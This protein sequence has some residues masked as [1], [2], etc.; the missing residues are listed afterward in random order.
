MHAKNQETYWVTNKHTEEFLPGWEMMKHRQWMSLCS[1]CGWYFSISHQDTYE[2]P[3]TVVRPDGIK[4]TLF[5]YFPVVVMVDIIRHLRAVSFL[6]DCLT[7]KVVNSWQ[8]DSFQLKGKHNGPQTCR[9]PCSTARVQPGRAGLSMSVWA[10]TKVCV[11]VWCVFTAKI[12]WLHEVPF[13]FEVWCNVFEPTRVC[14]CVPCPSSVSSG[15]TGCRN[16]WPAALPVSDWSSKRSSFAWQD[17]AVF[18]PLKQQKTSRYTFAITKTS[19]SYISTI[20]S[21]LICLHEFF[22]TEYGNAYAIWN[23]GWSHERA[24]PWYSVHQR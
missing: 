20:L 15:R 4:V 9:D 18:R 14:V 10:K 1:G 23:S 16:L 17:L 22:D 13:S 6:S 7:W 21:C 8:I 2:S 19:G 5:P 24:L 12:R 3:P 11:C